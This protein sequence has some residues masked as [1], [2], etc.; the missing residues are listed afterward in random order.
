MARFVKWDKG[1]DAA[2]SSPIPCTSEETMMTT[3]Y[4]SLDR[5]THAA[6]FFVSIVITTTLLGSLLL[7]IG[8][9]AQPIRMVDV[10]EEV[11]VH[12]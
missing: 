1:R 6:I 11:V 2:L 4:R 3:R 8:H 5:S 7:A 10:I 9:A 12:G